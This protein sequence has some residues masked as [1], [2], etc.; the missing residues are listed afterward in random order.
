MATTTSSASALPA[1]ETTQSG[2]I[3]P[4]G[5]QPEPGSGVPP[6]GGVEPEAD[7]TTVGGT[8]GGEA[9]AGGVFLVTRTA[10]GTAL[11]ETNFRVIAPTEDLA[12]EARQRLEEL[13]AKAALGLFA[14]VDVDGY[15]AS[16]A[17]RPVHGICTA[18]AAGVTCV[19]LETLQ[20]DN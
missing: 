15:V 7:T 17:P 20:G 5:W 6:G 11:A 2:L 13:Q 9:L 3:L 4:E 18:T 19:P 1:A 14:D 16:V 8:G 10:D 12:N